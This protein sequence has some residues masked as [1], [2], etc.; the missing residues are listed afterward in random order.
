MYAEIL[1]RCT[2][3]ILLIQTGL[4]RFT[5]GTYPPH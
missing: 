3:Q 4:R 2:G 1:T 5:V